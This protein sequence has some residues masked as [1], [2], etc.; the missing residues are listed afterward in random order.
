[1]YETCFAMRKLGA[2][3]EQS[4]KMDFGALHRKKSS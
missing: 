1:M 3:R 2:A 4:I